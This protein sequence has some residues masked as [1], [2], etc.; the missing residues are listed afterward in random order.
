MLI[1]RCI[2]LKKKILPSVLIRDSIN[3][4]KTRKV[5]PFFFIIALETNLRKVSFMLL[6]KPWKEQFYCR[7]MN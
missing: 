2:W 5:F 6:F 1:E 4:G 3:K 7:K